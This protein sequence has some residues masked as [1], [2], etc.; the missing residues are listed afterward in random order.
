MK[1]SGKYAVAASVWC[2]LAATAQAQAQSSVTL[3]GVMD[4]GLE[5]VSHAGA[6]GS[7][8][9]YRV[10]SGNTAASRWGLRG[11]EALGSDMS[12]IF[13]LESGFL[14]DTGMAGF[15]G[16]LF[17]R[18]AFVGIAGPWG[19]VTLGRQN[20]ILFDFFI[21]FDTN[22]YAPYSVLA[23]DAQF[24]GRADNAIKYTGNFGELTISALYSAGYDS[25]IASGGEVP[26]A[27][28]VGQ[29]IGTG[30]SYTIGKF[31]LAIA[32]DQRRGTSTV[33]AGN[34]E[35]R[36]AAGFLY[37]SGPFTAEAGYRLLQDGL[38]SPAS[39]SHLYW[40]G[41]A[42]AVK[43]ALTL[44]AGIYRTDKRASADDAISYVLQAA[45]TLSKRTE[46]YV[47]ASYMDNAG[48][49]TLGVASATKVAP[50]VGQTG[51]A[52]GMKHIF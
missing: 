48:R 23:H 34:I 20:N 39:R 25:T 51:L 36:Y 16:R 52:A 33:T 3:Y 41:G 14:T 43:P 4:A 10:T 28:R 49:S 13:V 31:G 7:G 5:Y 8:S 11:K 32:Y 26:G 22:R 21:P 6:D 47:N 17:G 12:A 35:R 29:E 44:R 38:G 2:L 1:T 30:A 9:V 15:G 42:Y 27:P 19:Q 50:G 45:Y 24:A 40:L 18:R 46:L 37:T